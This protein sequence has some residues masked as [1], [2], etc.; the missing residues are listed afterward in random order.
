MKR[1]AALFAIAVVT[2]CPSARCQVTLNAGETYTY[3]FAAL[4]LTGFTVVGAPS[5]LLAVG[6]NASSLQPGDA[7]RFEMFEGSPHGTPSFSRTVTADSAP[8]DFHGL[9]Y[10]VWDDLQGSVRFTMISGSAVIDSFSVS[11]LRVAGSR[12][13]NSYSIAVVPEPKA[14]LRVEPSP[15]ALVIQWPGSATNFV[16]ETTQDLSVPSHW[17]AVTNAVERVDEMYSM[18]IDSEAPARFYR[19]RRASGLNV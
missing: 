19:L 9:V 10:G 7:L 14:V 8:L 18:R 11:V 12:G 2:V 17:E 13:L 1:V 5:G 3:E 4:P 15:M 6:V 16:L